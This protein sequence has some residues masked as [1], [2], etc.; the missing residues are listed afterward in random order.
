MNAAMTAKTLSG[1]IDTD[2]T[3]CHARPTAGRARGQTPSCFIV[4][5]NVTVPERDRDRNAPICHRRVRPR[6]TSPGHLD[7]S[8]R[9]RLDDEDRTRSTRIDC[10]TFSTPEDRHSCAG[11]AGA[12]FAIPGS[13]GG[14][15]GSGNRRQP[16]ARHSV[17]P[18][19]HDSAR[20]VARW[21]HGQQR[22]RWPRRLASAVDEAV[23]PSISRRATDRAR[24]RRRSSSVSGAGAARSGQSSGGGGGGSGGMMLLHAS[25]FSITVGAKLVANGG[26]GSSGGDSNSAVLASR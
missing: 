24:R 12:S 10:G 14:N 20:A 15:G 9:R 2:G 21:L 18:F 17:A 5:T 3:M 23:A 16:L 11:G 1:N 13:V 22:R 26:A 19:L 4:G 6:S 25:T 7:A 8:S